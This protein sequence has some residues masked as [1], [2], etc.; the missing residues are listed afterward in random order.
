VNAVLASGEEFCNPNMK[1]SN[2]LVVVFMLIDYAISVSV[3]EQHWWYS[4]SMCKGPVAASYNFTPG[5]CYPY[6][7]SF[8]VICSSSNVVTLS[9]DDDYCSLNCTTQFNAKIGQCVILDRIGYSTMF[10]CY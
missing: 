4:N 8:V 3:V 10:F 1:M 5:Y 9:C 6:P 2:V 7:D